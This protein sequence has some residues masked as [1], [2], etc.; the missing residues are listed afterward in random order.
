MD[1][2]L[3]G[4]DLAEGMGLFIGPLASYV[5]YRSPLDSRLRGND[6][7]GKARAVH[8]AVSIYTA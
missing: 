3:S 4:H 5:R 8:W 2:R 6:D 1:A 7:L